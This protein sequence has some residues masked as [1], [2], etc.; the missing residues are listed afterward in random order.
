M[1]APDFWQSDGPA[2]RLLDPLGKAY[3]LVGRLRRRLIT[4]KTASVPVIC[5]GNLTVGGAGKTPTA[6]KVA[7]RLKAKGEI[8][9][10][11]TRGYGGRTRGPKLVDLARHDAEE[12][13]DEALL[14][15]RITP[16]W[17]SRDRVAGAKA[18]VE[19]GASVIILD[20]GH[21]NP[22]LA[23]DL[24]LVVVDGAVGFGNNRLVPAGPL[25][26]TIGGG[27]SRAD[28]LIV[29]GG[30]G[31]GAIEGTLPRLNAE[32]RPSAG[33]PDLREKRVVAFAGIG[34]PQKF[35]NTLQELGAVL[36]DVHAFADHYRYKPSEIETILEQ[37]RQVDAVCITTEKDHV[38]IPLPLGNYV[39]ELPIELR[40]EADDGLD[41]LLLAAIE[42]R[43]DDKLRK[44]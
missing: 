35:F 12:V 16:T 33:S 39:K 23:H 18:A 17:V 34:R 25:R 6:I 2:A 31:H 36:V 1:R 15:A 4:P 40:F 24:A 8:P 3:G 9:H 7:E 14:L 22:H 26:E 19:A 29:I 13:G 28:A 27:L 20:D 10:M 43:G 44:I 21:Q 11:L 30:S 42:G 32:L 38:R 5:I 41:K 37:A